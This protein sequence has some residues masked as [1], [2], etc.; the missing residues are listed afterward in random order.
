MKLT[1]LQINN[2]YVALGNINLNDVCTKDIAKIMRARKAMRSLYDDYVA[3]DEDVRKAQ[4]NYDVLVELESKVRTDKEDI[5]YNELKGSFLQGL[6]EA[7]KPELDKEFDLDIEPISE[8]ALAK[9]ISNN[10]LKLD[11]LDVI[12]CIIE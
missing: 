2:A 9:I 8:E 4:P 3:F 7:I 12:Q 11:D 1:Q 6:F 5:R 10:G